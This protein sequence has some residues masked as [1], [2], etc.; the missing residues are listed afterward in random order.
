M[1]FNMSCDSG[2]AWIKEALDERSP[3]LY[4]ITGSVNIKY[5]WILG[6]KNIYFDYFLNIF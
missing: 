4:T 1:Y 5:L 2:V 3:R 6:I